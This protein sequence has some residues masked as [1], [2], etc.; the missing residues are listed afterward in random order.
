MSLAVDGDLRQDAIRAAW[1]SAH[2]IPPP[3]VASQVHGIAVHD[4]DAEAYRPGPGDALVSR[5]RQASL[6]VF[7]ADCP[8]LVLVAPDALA[9]AHCGWRGTVA[10]IVGALVGALA[11][12]TAHPPASWTALVGPGV[13]PDDY[14]VDATV[15]AAA[16]W[17]TGTLAPGR[18]GHAWLDLP[19]AV[20]AQATAC[21]VGM[22][23]RTPLCTSRDPRLR[24]FRRHGSGPPQLLVAW[25]A[26]CAT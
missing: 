6:G 19:A 16:S 23:A 5:R 4:V 12:R 25:R 1:C 10:G 11:L 2:G 20:A 14:E 15:L 21:G 7:G 9:V 18:P 17:P 8:S 13:H 26:P 24:S 3:S 22:V